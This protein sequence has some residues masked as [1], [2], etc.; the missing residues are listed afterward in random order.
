MKR[1]GFTGTRYGMTD[2]QLERV[3]LEVDLRARFGIEG[4]HGDCIGADAQ[5]HGVVRRL[6]D[7]RIVLHP[8]TNQEHR[9]FCVA[10]E[11][12]PQFPYMKRN[13]NIVDLA[14]LMIAGPC[15]MQEQARG[16]TWRTV[17]LA[18]KAKRPLIVVWPD[19]TVKR[20]R[21]P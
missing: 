9:A 13:R 2:A 16:G 1:I 12:R 15:E 6:A 10:D 8:P 11:T 19:G 7:S 4:H 21:C 5:F 20:E 17:Q 14:D 18:R 3:T